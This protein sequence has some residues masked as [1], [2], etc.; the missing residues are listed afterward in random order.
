MAELHLA[1]LLFDARALERTRERHGLPARSTDLGYLVHGQ[2]AACFGELAPKPFRVRDRRGRVEVL[3]YT[4]ADADALR[5]QVALYAE[6]LFADALVDLAAKRMPTGWS[7]SQRLGFEVRACPIVRLAHRGPGGEQAGAEVDAFLHACWQVDDTT[8]IDRGT[9]YEAWLR[10]QLAPATEL[11]RV[12]LERFAL[13]RLHRKTHAGDGERKARAIARP[14][15]LLV[16]ELRIRDPAAFAA[17][18]RRGVGR[19]RAFGFGLLLLRPPG[20]R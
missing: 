20:S 16:G 6:P 7:E 19:H 8:R 2:L 11:E 1:Q 14:D 4:E 9:V 13:P 15:A 17:L 5:E 12:A 10:D 18:L 3:G